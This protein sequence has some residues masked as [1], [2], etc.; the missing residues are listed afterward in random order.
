MQVKKLPNSN[1]QLL[2]MLLILQEVYNQLI[3][4]V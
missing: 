1:L 3:N 4:P 2:Y